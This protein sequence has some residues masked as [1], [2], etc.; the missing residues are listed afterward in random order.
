MGIPV[1]P[2]MEGKALTKKK[3][4]YSEEDKKEV[5]ERLAKIGYLG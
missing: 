3:S 1:P 4:A 5:K 2:D